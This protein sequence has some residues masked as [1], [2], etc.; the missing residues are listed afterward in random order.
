M[1]TLVK[2]LKHITS[3]WSNQSLDYSA[4]FRL[5]KYTIRVEDSGRT[6][7]HNAVTRQLVVLDPEEAEILE[8][9]PVSRSSVMEQL[10]SA[11]F[12][13]PINFDE[14]KL[15]QNIR[16]ILRKLDTAKNQNIITNYTIFPTTACNARCYYCFEQGAKTITMTEQTADKVVDFITHHCGKNNRV[17]ITWFG[18]EPT[19]AAN[20]IDQIS[21]GLK[22]NGVEFYSDMNTNGYLFDEKLVQ[23]ALSLW[24]L[25]YLQICFDGLEENH[26]SIKNYTNVRDNPYERTLRNIGLLLDA[27]IGVGL[28]M[29][30]D[31][32]NYQDFEGLV[33]EAAKRFT[34]Y[35]G[36]S[37]YAFPIN[38]KY[39][40]KDGIVRHGDD[41]WFTAKLAELNEI[42]RNSGLYRERQILP[43]LKYHCCY[44][45]NNNAIDVTPDGNLVRCCECFGDEETVGTIWDGITDIDL[46][47]SWNIYA[48]YDKC[49]DCVYYP[50]CVRIKRCP[51]EDR[52]LFYSEWNLRNERTI[53]ETLRHAVDKSVIKEDC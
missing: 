10:I 19:V 31:V 41:D 38:G 25:K 4:A 42:S 23:K 43:F 46:Y 29:N 37:V 8:K 2:P 26:N 47:N 35:K 48:E 17:H 33:N 18:G 49:R 6:L 50:S 12:L 22:K 27:G 20:R 7:L 53:K 11:H 15:V 32:S 40:D 52:C 36:L 39:A 5:M 16:C 28:R 24:N 3:L 13:V 14:H 9:L 1:I 30:F 51:G 34:G 44:A 21:D 45:E